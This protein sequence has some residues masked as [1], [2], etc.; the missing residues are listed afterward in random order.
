MCGSSTSKPMSTTKGF[1]LGRANLK[2]LYRASTNF[3]DWSY[4][5]GQYCKGFSGDAHY[6]LQTFKVG[7]ILLFHISARLGKFLTTTP[8]ESIRTARAPCP[9]QRPLPGP[10]VPPSGGVIGWCVHGSM[11]LEY[12]TSFYP[13][14]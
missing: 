13:V 5:S 4:K 7:C 11:H 12:S 9:H 8:W 2:G 3:V 10:M 14:E 1:S 6:G